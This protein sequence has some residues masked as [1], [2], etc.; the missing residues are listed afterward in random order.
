MGYDENNWNNDQA[1]WKRTAYLVY[2]SHVCYV[3]GSIFYLQLS[4]VSFRWGRYTRDHRVPQNVLDEDN[5]EI[6]EEWSYENKRA[7]ILDVREVYWVQYVRA[8]VLGACSYAA[9]G[10][11]EMCMNRNGNT[12]RNLLIT[13][14]G[15]IGM[16]DALSVGGNSME[17][18]SAI[19]L[20]FYLCSCNRLDSFFAGAAIECIVSY[21]YLAGFDWVWLLYLDSIACLFWLYCAVVGAAEE[22]NFSLTRLV[23]KEKAIS[24][25]PRS[26]LFGQEKND[27]YRR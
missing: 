23:C 19:S 8:N 7:D 14:G 17:Y 21:A 18:G 5:D 9:M 3:L 12:L 13:L 16:F 1:A 11:V 24:S 10:F 25:S 2:L 20:T 15:L 26:Q 6:W 22:F 4:I 27:R